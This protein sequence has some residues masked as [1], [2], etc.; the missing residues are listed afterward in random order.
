MPLLVP[1]AGEPVDS[2]CMATADDRCAFRPARFARR[3]LG[4]NDILIE[5]KF[6]GVCH[7]DV[8]VAAGHAEALMGRK[9]PCVPGHELAGV[10]VAVGAAVTRVRVGE[11]VGVGCMVD[12][13]GRCGACRRGEEQ[14]CMSNTTT[15]N[16]KPGVRSA[17]GPGAPAHTLGG[18]TNAFVVDERFAVRIPAGYPLE[19]A[20]PIQ[21]AG[22]TV[23]DP[24]RRHGAGPGTRLGVVG[25]GGLGTMA[26]KLGKALGCVVTAITR[27]P[28][29]AAY[30]VDRAGADASLISTDAAAMAAAAKS[31]DLI[32]DTAP[33][34]H[35]LSPYLALLAPGRT[36]AGRVRRLVV[37][38]LTADLVA[39]MVVGSLTC[40]TSRVVGGN[41]GSV[42][43]TQAVID[44]CA[45]KNIVPELKVVPVEALSDVYTALAAGNDT[46]VRYVLD[47][48]TLD[49]GAEERCRGVAP[50]NLGA[51]PRPVSACSIVSAIFRLLCCRR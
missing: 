11:A 27:S 44:L 45:A 1:G 16:G 9:Y 35:D 21:C 26:I 18:Y 23:F 37:L 12:S 40:G 31:L 28:S 13:C 7:T 30:A 42:E 6:V 46:G 25:I 41:I 3:A 24:L 20:G 34:A 32:L 49:A 29:K 2:L 22:V 50:P 17:V 36:A 39:S 15:Y 33:D 19:A 14:W 38:G 4:A 51:P 5:M 8:H 47:L 43:C 48:S 10:C